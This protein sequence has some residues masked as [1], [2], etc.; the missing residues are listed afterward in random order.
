MQSDQAISAAP[1]P[2]GSNHPGSQV[3][4]RFHHLRSQLDVSRDPKTVVGTGMNSVSESRQVTNGERNK[5]HDGWFAHT[6]PS[7]NPLSTHAPRTR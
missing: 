5:G 7:Q 3:P 6:P 1:S 2:L 4:P